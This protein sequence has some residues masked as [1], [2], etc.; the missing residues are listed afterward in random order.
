[1][2]VGP[3]WFCKDTHL[4]WDYAST[5]A[6]LSDRIRDQRTHSLGSQDKQH[7]T[8]ASHRCLPVDR[9]I[10]LYS[11]VLLL[12]CLAISYDVVLFYIALRLYSHNFSTPLQ[13]ISHGWLIT[14]CDVAKARTIILILCC[15]RVHLHVC[16]SLS[17][18]HFAYLLYVVGLF[19]LPLCYLALF[20][21]Y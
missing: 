19:C 18:V 2:S 15:F 10:Q 8:F 16:L 17:P 4:F 12:S 21:W 9:H 7:V 6:Q 3:N 1:M 13:F 5:L 11:A 14:H 20:K